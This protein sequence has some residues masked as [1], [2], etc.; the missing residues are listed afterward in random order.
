MLFA[1]LV[2][3]DRKSSSPQPWMIFSILVLL[4]VAGR[5]ILE[6]LP[7][8]QPVTAMVVIIAVLWGGSRAAAFGISVAILSNLIMGHGIWT[9][10]QAAAW[11]LI[12]LVSGKAANMFKDDLGSLLESRM[13]VLA[14]ISGFIFDW[15]VSISVLHTAEPAFL[16]LY[17]LNGLPFD[18]IHGVGNAAFVVWM[19]SPM[20]N[21]IHRHSKLNAT[22]SVNSDAT[23]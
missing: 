2:F 9:A 17:I 14:F 3:A 21:I 12:A 6:P 8:I 15:I 18:L 10:Y 1:M 20:A 23:A 5:V 16:A 13:V 4:A 7:N 11:T 19:A 22:Q